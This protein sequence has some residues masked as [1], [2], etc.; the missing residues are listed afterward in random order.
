MSEERP[1]ISS[2]VR[3]FAHAFR[4][5]GFGLRTQ[6]NLRVHALCTV[7][8]MGLGIWLGLATWEWCAVLMACGAVWTAELMNT[9]IERLADRVTL[10]RDAL[11]RD[12]KDAAAGAVLVASIFAAGVGAVIFLPKLLELQTF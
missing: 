1:A 12:A 6:R 10:E 4:G 7:L 3:G 5:I 8:V 2:F 11:I 9:A